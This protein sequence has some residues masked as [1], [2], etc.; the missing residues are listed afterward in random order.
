MLHYSSVVHA[1]LAFP[2]LTV[3]SSTLPCYGTTFLCLYVPPSLAFICHLPCLRHL[4]SAIL[5]SHACLH[6]YSLPATNC[7]AAL[8]PCLFLTTFLAFSTPPFAPSHHHTLPALLVTFPCLASCLA[9]PSL[10]G[11]PAVLA[12]LTL[13]S[14]LPSLHP[15]PLCYTCLQFAFL[16]AHTLPAFPHAMPYPYFCATC[17]FPFT[18]LHSS[19]T[20]F[21]LCLT[22]T[23]CVVTLAFLLLLLAFKLYIYVWL[24]FLCLGFCRFCLWF[25][26]LYYLFMQFP[27]WFSP[28][29]YMSSSAGFPIYVLPLYIIPCLPF[30]GSMVCVGSSILPMLPYYLGYYP[31][32]PF[33]TYTHPPL[34]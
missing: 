19:T 5:P 29:L 31:H 15:F 1:C 8:L 17:R 22:T 12:R 10:A 24:L 26:S 14:F 33:I 34:V 28:P 18:C 20:C 6:S 3:Y 4:P 30:C 27:T 13:G 2:L 23:A 11:T 9:I 16:P 32:V 7:H 25:C 21:L